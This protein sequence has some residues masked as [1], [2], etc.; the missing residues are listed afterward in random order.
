MKLFILT[1]SVRFIIYFLVLFPTFL[2]LDSR[3]R[4]CVCVKFSDCI[5]ICTRACYLAFVR[6]KTMRG[7]QKVTHSYSI[8]DSSV[9]VYSATVRLTTRKRKQQHIYTCNLI[10][11]T[12]GRAQTTTI[13]KHTYSTCMLKKKNSCHQFVLSAFYFQTTILLLPLWFISQIAKCRI[14]ITHT[15]THTPNFASDNYDVCVCA[16]AQYIITIHFYTGKWMAVARIKVN[17]I[18]GYTTASRQ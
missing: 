7:P 10:I 15:H 11:Y 16:C 4:L 9:V 2:T 12:L 8:C 5:F 1:S 14:H 6:F 13:Y 18:F 3:R 17:F